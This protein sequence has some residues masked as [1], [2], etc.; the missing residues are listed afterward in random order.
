ML[1]GEISLKESFIFRINIGIQEISLKFADLFGNKHKC[2]YAD[3]NQ[4]EPI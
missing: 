2:Q 1:S 3:T 4:H